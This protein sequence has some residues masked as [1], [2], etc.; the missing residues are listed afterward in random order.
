MIDDA[1]RR[2]RRHRTIG[3]A[4]LIAVGLAAAWLAG[5]GGGHNPAGNSPQTAGRPLSASTDARWTTLERCLTQAERALSASN[6]GD[7]GR[8][9][10][11]RPGVL[12]VYDDP[13]PGYAGLVGVFTYEGTFEQARHAATA[14]HEQRGAKPAFGTTAGLAIGNLAYYFTG[15]VSS[16]ALEAMTSCLAAGYRHQ[17]TWP[18]NIDP[19]SLPNTP[20]G[21]YRQTTQG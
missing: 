21:I 8:V 17:P 19:A 18:T 6:P 14:K 9:V 2:H 7:Q 4:V 20:G 11:T 5:G 3:L 13:Q 12:D 10:L 1:R 16:P 15:W